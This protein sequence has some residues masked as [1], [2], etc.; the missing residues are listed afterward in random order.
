M[1]RGGPPPPPPPG[2]GP[3]KAPKDVPE[4]IADALDDR[5]GLLDAIRKG[6]TLKKVGEGGKKGGKKGG[7]GKGG[8]KKSSVPG[9]PD[10]PEKKKPPPPAAPDLFGELVGALTRRRNAFTN[11]GGPG[12]KAAKA[13]DGSDEEGSDGG[14][15]IPGPQ[16]VT[17]PH[18]EFDQDWDDS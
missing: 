2:G 10:E 12:K 15:M 7:K 18:L 14:G 17:S 1:K 9:L 3:K 6:H 8:G 5:G 4:D 13:D 16:S 11:P